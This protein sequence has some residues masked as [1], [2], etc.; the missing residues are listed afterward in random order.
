MARQQSS[1]DRDS[2]FL[3]GVTRGSFIPNPLPL[4]QKAV[5]FASACHKGEMRDDDCPYIFHPLA[6]CKT[7]ITLGVCDDHILAA[8]I[9]HDVVENKRATMDVIGQEFGKEVAHLVD[10]QTKLEGEA[11]EN[12][13]ARVASEVGGILGKGADRLHNINN[14][15]GI[16][17]PPRL[18]RYVLETEKYVLPMLKDS[19]YAILE[20]ADALVVLYDS[21]LNIVNLAKYY[22]EAR[23][24]NEQ[25]R[26]KI[27][28][29][30]KV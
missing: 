4:T 23:E 19:R 7:L 30:E 5:T 1:L 14:M 17:D 20:Y 26:L 25:L 10:I 15:A 18:K 22:I 9:L 3:Y 6:A 21:I 13:Y 27:A 24:E 29:Q 28:E 8:M 16:F 2:I 12:Y 11:P